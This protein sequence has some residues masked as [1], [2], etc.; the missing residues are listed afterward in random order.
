MRIL[1]GADAPP[2]PN[3]GAAGTVFATN[4]AL[5]QLGHEVDTIWYDDLPHR[6]RHWNL[7]YLLELPRAYQRCV[8]QRA[9]QTEY[10]V[11]QLSQPHAWMAARDNQRRRR[12]AILINRSHGLEN[13]ADAA[14]AYWQPKIGGR[15][16][17][18]P[19]SVFSSVLQRALHRHIDLVVRHA[20][21][22]I[23][24][25]QEIRDFLIDQHG[26]D[27]QRIVVIP[28]GVPDE[29]IAAPRPPLTDHRLQRLLHVGQHSVIKGAPLMVAAVEA[30]LNGNPEL[31]FTWLC[32][33]T[34]H[35][36]A[37][38]LF[39]PQFRVR[40]SMQ[41]WAAQQDLLKLLDSHGVFVAHSIYEGAAKACT[42]AMARGLVLVTSAAGALKDHVQDGVNGS[43]VRIGDVEKMAA[44]IL[45]ACADVGRS[46][47]LG[48][49]AAQTMQQMSWGACAASAIKYYSRIQAMRG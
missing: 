32:S 3:S 14:L 29:F 4:A 47:Q 25:A 2:D 1:V 27:P 22:M 24:P 40:V 17:R 44:D 41:D 12:R 6:I 9:S 49:A 20:D 28:H 30:A 13:M 19:R 37:L 26:A 21:G 46:Q 48:R 23:V 31:S 36:E 38:G 5:R 18:F 45:A 16:S 34:H 39:R 33:R 35:P 7:H 42:E 10:D 11:I 8:Q 43:I 15:V